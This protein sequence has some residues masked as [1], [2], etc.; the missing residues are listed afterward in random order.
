MTNKKRCFY[1]GTYIRYSE[2]G[3]HARR[4]KGLLERQIR[5]V[6]VKK[7]VKK[8]CA[9]FWLTRYLINSVLKFA[10]LLF[11]IKRYNQM[12]LRDQI[13]DFVVNTV[14]IHYMFTLRCSEIALSKKWINQFKGESSSFWLV[15]TE[16]VYLLFVTFRSKLV[17]P[18]CFVEYNCTTSQ[19]K[20]LPGDPEF[21]ANIYC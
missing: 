18:L 5:F 6:T 3:A 16:I 4:K 17:Y 15:Q 14:I 2:K 19:G 1:H 10:A 12:P 9:Y 11:I 13:S 21:T 8:I 20:H 7:R